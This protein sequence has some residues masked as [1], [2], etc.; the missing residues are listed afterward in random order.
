[1]PTQS[2][3][4]TS[5]NLPAAR[6]HLLLVLAGVLEGDRPVSKRPWRLRAADGNVTK[7]Y[8]LHDLVR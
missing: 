2:A 3:H 7:N 8:L 4:P 1:M 5:P 6:Y